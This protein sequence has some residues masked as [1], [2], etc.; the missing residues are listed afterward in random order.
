MAGCVKEAFCFVRDNLEDGW[1]GEGAGGSGK[2]SK[3]PLDGGVQVLDLDCQRASWSE[4][5]T[6][7]KVLEEE[8]TAEFME[9]GW[10]L[11][12]GHGSCIKISQL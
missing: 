9:V 12:W 6:E 8:G 1:N 7:S 11:G 5:R 4:Q 3:V 10:C 2:V